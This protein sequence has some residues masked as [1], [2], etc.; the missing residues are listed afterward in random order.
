MGQVHPTNSS[1]QSSFDVGDLVLI[2]AFVN[3]QTHL[4]FS[5]LPKPIGIAGNRFHQ[6]VQKVIAW[7]IDRSKKPGPRQNNPTKIEIFQIGIN[8]LIKTG[9]AVVG[10]I[11]TAFS[12]PQDY[13]ESENKIPTPASRDSDFTILFELLGLEPDRFGSLQPGNQA[14]LQVATA[15]GSKSEFWESLSYQKLPI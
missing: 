7:K 6:W 10:E 8:E 9:M 13:Q 14:F 4:E 12:H 3:S 5:D 11:A 15:S 1:W 2:P